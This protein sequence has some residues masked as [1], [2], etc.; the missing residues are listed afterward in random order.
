MSSPTTLDAIG[1]NN[2]LRILDKYH[3]RYVLDRKDSPVAYL[4]MNTRDWKTDY[5]DDV[6]V[7]LER[8][9]SGDKEGGLRVP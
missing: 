2:T 8:M 1:V 7:L 6:T 3:I 5:Q 4:L 9:D